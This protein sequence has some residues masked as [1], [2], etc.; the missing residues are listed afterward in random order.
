MMMQELK[1]K[2]KFHKLNLDRNSNEET[3]DNGCISVRSPGR[4]QLHGQLSP[5]LAL[6]VSCEKMLYF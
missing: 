4:G 5:K 2:E 6:T 1:G 3:K